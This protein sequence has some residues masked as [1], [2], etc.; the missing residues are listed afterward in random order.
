MDPALCASLGKEQTVAMALTS[1]SS[2]VD[3][4]LARELALG[5]GTAPPQSD[6]VLLR[7]GTRGIGAVAEGL[8][9]ALADGK[10]VLA[11]ELLTIA[12]VCAG[13]LSVITPAPPIQVQV[14]HGKTVLAALMG[15]PVSSAV[16]ATATAVVSHGAILF[17]RATSHPL[18]SHFPRSS[19]HPPACGAS[20]S[21]TPL[22]HGSSCRV[23]VG[24]A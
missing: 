16:A 9:V 13:R 22:A 1:L 17:S 21:H 18:T 19:P 11:R 2:C 6:D 8:P 10:N 5:A 23:I 15:S 14:Q 12:S 3:A 4:L 20:H 7:L 24:P